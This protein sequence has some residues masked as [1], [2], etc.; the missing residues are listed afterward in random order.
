MTAT[1]P[2]QA[3]VAVLA[4]LIVIRLMVP[5]VAGAVGALA[6]RTATLP[7]VPVAGVV[8][9]LEPATAI[10]PMRV[11]AGAQ[12]R[13]TAI[14]PMDRA[15]VVADVWSI[16]TR[17]IRRRRAAS[18]G[19]GLGPSVF[20]VGRRFSGRCRPIAKQHLTIRA[21]HL[22]SYIVAV[23]AGANGGPAAPQSWGDI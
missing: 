10:P 13:P 23:S 22:T 16:A 11:D 19:L 5:G 14:R 17:S 2:M 20:R 1:R 18:R 4:P 8:L 21:A 15:A 3:A 12:V 7:M 9:E 6:R